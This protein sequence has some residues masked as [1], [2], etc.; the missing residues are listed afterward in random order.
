MV[1]VPPIGAYVAYLPDG[2]TTFIVGAD[3]YYYYNGV[4]FRPYS[5]GYVIVSPPPSQPATT[6]APAASAQNNAPSQTSTTSG[7]GAEAKSLSSAPGASLAAAGQQKSASS[8]TV[9]VGVPN[10]K[11]GFSSVKL[12]KHKDGYIGPQGEFYAGH[13]TVDELKALY[14]N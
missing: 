2:S 5:D 10:S 12:V 8:D 13:P 6:T 11:G 9:T 1:V 3:R 4:Y 7:T 14:G